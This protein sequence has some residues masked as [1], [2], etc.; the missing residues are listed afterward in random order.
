MMMFRHI[1]TVVTIT[2]IF[3][4]MTQIS[5][6]KEI[7]KSTIHKVKVLYAADSGE[8]SYVKY[9][10][11]GE[12]SWVSIT[13]ADVKVGDIIVFQDV[14]TIDNYHSEPLKM[15]F[16]KLLFARGV[17]IVFREKGHFKS[18]EEEQLFYKYIDY[19]FHADISRLSPNWMTTNDDLKFIEW[20]K[21][22]KAPGSESTVIKVLNDAYNSGDTAIVAAIFI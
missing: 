11:N 9:E 19:R 4:C 14:L 21:N 5:F 16:S 17:K 10:E 13:K 3:F 1:L 22:T 12:E 18:P 15:T 8:D 6:A 20:A 2:C 7:V